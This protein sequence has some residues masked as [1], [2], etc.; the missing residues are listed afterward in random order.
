MQILTPNV[1]HCKNIQLNIE[2]TVDNFGYSPPAEHR[3]QSLVSLCGS[4]QIPHANPSALLFFYIFHVLN[5]GS[6]YV[7][8][9]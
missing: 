6:F 3:S 7:D 2:V 1:F 9:Q 8:S 5:G 4:S